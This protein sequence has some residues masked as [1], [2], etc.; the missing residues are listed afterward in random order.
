MRCHLSV[1]SQ[2]CLRE[3]T[4]FLCTRETSN[5]VLVLCLEL[6]ALNTKAILIL[7]DSLKI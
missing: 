7:L 2:N 5:E 6:I 4:Y 1:Q 3:E